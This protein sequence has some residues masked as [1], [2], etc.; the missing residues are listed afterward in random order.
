LLTRVPLV[1]EGQDH[2]PARD[3]LN[4][5]GQKPDLRSVA[6]MVVTV[7]VSVAVPPVIR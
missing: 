5:T 1:H 6:A 7:F 4:S 2:R 3:L